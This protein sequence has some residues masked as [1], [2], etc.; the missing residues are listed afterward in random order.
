MDEAYD[1]VLAITVVYHIVEIMKLLTPHE[2]ADK[3]GRLTRKYLFWESGLQRER[4]KEN[5]LRVGNFREYLK[6]AN[7]YATG[8]LREIGVFIK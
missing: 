1:I 4:E 6:L 8:K 7:S 2:A 5:I 3:L